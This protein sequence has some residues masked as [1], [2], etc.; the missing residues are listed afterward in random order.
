MEYNIVCIRRGI[1]ED[2]VQRPLFPES[3]AYRA[4]CNGGA[5]NNLAAGR[6]GGRGRSRKTG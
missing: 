3:E 5:G 2:A 6:G 4:Q 1:T